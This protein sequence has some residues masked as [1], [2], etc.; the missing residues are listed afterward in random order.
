MNRV[1]E[2]LKKCGT[3]Y[4]ATNEN[5]APRVRPFGTVCIYNDKLYIQTGKSKPVYRQIIECPTVEICAFDGSSWIRLSGTLVP[6]EDV[7]AKKYMLDL[8]PMLRGMYDEND[9]NTIVLYFKDATAVIS[10]FTAAPITIVF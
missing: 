5:G 9:D 8:Y 4:L 2:F 7:A 10:S 3:Y 1:Y 6:D